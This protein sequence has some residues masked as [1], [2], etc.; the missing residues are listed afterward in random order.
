M[1][2]FLI[3]RSAVATS[4]LANTGTRQECLVVAQ[5]L[6]ELMLTLAATATLT[7]SSMTFWAVSAVRLEAAQVPPGTAEASLEAAS[8]EVV[9]PAVDREH[10]STLMLKQWSR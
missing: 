9:F 3:L 6:Q 7:I 10:Q 8:P 1:R 4:N 5:V 2:C